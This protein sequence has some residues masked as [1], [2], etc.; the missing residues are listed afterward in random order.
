MG[1][2]LLHREGAPGQ[3]RLRR[4]AAQAVLRDE[5]RAGERRV[6]RRQPALRPDLQGAQRPAGLPPGHVRVYDVFDEDGKQLAIFI[7]DMYARE[8]KRGGA[9]MNSY[10]VAVRPD[11]LQA[12][13]RQP[14]QH[15][16]AAGRQA[17]AADLGRGD[18]R[19]PRVRPR[20]ARHVLEREVSATSPAPACRATSSSIRR[21]STRCGPT[22]RRSWRTT[23]STTRPARRCRRNCSTRCW[24]REVQPGLRDHRV[25]GRGDARPA[26]APGHGRPG[27]RRRRRDG[28]RGRGAEEG[29]R[30][31]RAGAAALPHAV[32][33]PHHGRL[34]GR[35]LR[36]HLV[37][38][39]STPTPSSGSS[40]TAA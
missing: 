15:P 11:R 34:L 32:L 39:C 6:L 21:R 22:G 30:R 12:G 3:V 36:L 1:L 23:P 26:L 29:R 10:V 40:R 17:D 18:H 28:V 14:P 38:K 25:P 27:A 7:A 20:A 19:V 35:L 8:S 31:L 33:L 37:A 9:W 2:G 5:E 4:V 24:P 16:E 13:G